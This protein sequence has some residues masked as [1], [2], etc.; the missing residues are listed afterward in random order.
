MALGSA[1]SNRLR[2]AIL[3]TVVNLVDGGM[4]VPAAVAPPPGP[5]RGRRGRRRG[6]RPRGGRGGPARRR[7]PAAPLGRDEPLLR[8]RQR[9]RT[10]PRRPRG[11]R[12]PPPGRRGGRRDRRRRGDRPM[13]QRQ[14]EV[15]GQDVRR[16]IPRGSA[17]P[18]PTAPRCSGASRCGCSTDERELGIKTCF[19]GRVSV[20]FRDA[21]AP[22]GPIEA[23]LPVLHE[24]AFEKIEAAPARGRAGG[25]DPLR[26]RGPAMASGLRAARG[27]PP[28]RPSAPGGTTAASSPPREAAPGLGGGAPWSG[29]GRSPCSGPPPWRTGPPPRRAGRARSR[30][31]GAGGASSSRSRRAPWRPRR[32]R[33][34]GPG[35]ARAPGTAPPSCTRPPSR[36]DGATPPGPARPGGS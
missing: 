12:R 21:S 17:P 36:P 10:R 31:R 15:D 9:G 28:R 18:S 32:R 11:G 13:T 3:Q 5:P 29:A 7:P 14:V 25:R 27:V 8:R 4:D 20:Q 33:P 23:L 6:G 22:D 1:G 35:A 24:L 26:L 16:W 30:S 34:S 19:V 2:S